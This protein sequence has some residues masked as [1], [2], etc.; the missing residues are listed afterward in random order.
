[1]TLTKT[2][3]KRPTLD[4]R[5]RTGQHHHHSPHY[6]KTYW[7]YLPILAV[8]VLGFAAN[9]WMGRLHRSVL[10]YATDM[11]AQALLD[12][13]NAER[14]DS[15][16]SALAINTQLDQAAQA[17]ADD[18]A[19]RDY[20]SHDTPDGKTPW[21][22]ITAAGYDY[23]TAGENLAY[24]FATAGDTVTGWM[25]S[26]EHRANI[27]NTTYRDVGFGIA[28]IPD[29]QS[30]G[31]E[32]LVVAMYGSLA[33][34]AVRAAQ[35]ASATPVS[36]L[37][38]AS[39][40]ATAPSAGTPLATATTQPAAAGAPVDTAQPA[41]TKPA[42]V[43][44]PAPQHISR[45]QLAASDVPASSVLAIVFGAAACLFLL[46]RHGIAW[47]KV[48]VR[49]ER[50]ALAHPALDLAAITLVAISIVLTHAA[51]VIR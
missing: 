51:G 27:L 30:G 18:M 23:Q 39:A 49:G 3:P 35:P 40:A 45:I 50:F 1:M 13:T 34:E 43:A 48:L 8:L 19:A 20:W 32:T 29:Y 44:E 36:G 28:N 26:P 17:K 16:E 6:V 22:F 47:H 21:T 41:T 12:D 14:A 24:G 46:F 33:G 42:D 15:G 38:P 9:G 7:P 10:G 4:H 31:P 11:S 37:H 2:K 25:N 5:R